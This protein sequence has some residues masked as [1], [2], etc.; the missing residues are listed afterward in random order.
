M[1]GDRRIAWAL[2]ATLAAGA[3]LRLL[4]VLAWKPAF[5][6]W[7]DAASYIGVSQS[8][9]FF[10]NELRP[11]G[12]PLVLRAM[13]EISPTLLFVVLV[14]HLLG[15]ASAAIMFFTVARTGI[16]RRL[17]LLPA[18]VMALGAPVFFMEHSA[19]SEAVFIL[20]MSISLYCG[21]R[22]T[23]GTS[24]WWPALGGLVLATAASV[25]VVAL[26]IL[27]L[28]AL[29][30]VF[31]VPSAAW[32]RRAAVTAAGVL[33]AFA[34]LV[35]YYVVEYAAEGRTGLSRNGAWNVYGRVA[36][37]ADCSKFTPPP[38]TGLL[39]ENVP[40]AKRPYTNQYTFNWYY[41][42][43][44]RYFGDP[45]TAGAKQTAAV[46]AF[47][48]EVVTHQPLDYLEEVGGATLRYIA[49]ESF[50]GYGGGYSW[51]DLVHH[52]VL[53]N[54]TYNPLGLRDA[55]PHY[56]DAKRFSVDRNL[57]TVLRTY[58]SGTRLQGPVFL[59]LALLT[60]L[61]PFLTTGR[62]RSAAV[63]FAI[64]AWVMLVIPVAT[65]EFSARTAVPA[66]GPF[67][68]AAAIGA[69]GALTAFARRRRRSLA[70]TPPA[71]PA[72]A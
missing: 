57:I 51:H 25:R 17:A 56:T 27:I 72:E 28:G 18:A 63:L 47:T 41:S 7:P 16:S 66:L 21:V 29:W 4:L 32:R 37:F 23:E 60:V 71:R 6:G 11:A 40:R 13:N 12:Y 30:L 31:A 38:G 19:N 49:P 67:V 24:L 65:V 45:H 22:T 46:E 20:L 59:V 53:F 34:L 9:D 8:G 69:Q 48:W 42:P 36:P 3:V 55:R 10:R 43:A 50:R 5:F 1:R 70:G 58:E 52:Q 14:H 61:A 68:A 44:I 35:P 2:V 64:S 39:C 54:S 15:L 33:G 62:A 26:P